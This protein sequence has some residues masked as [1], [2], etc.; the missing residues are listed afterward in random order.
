MVRSRRDE[1]LDL[2]LPVT[3]SGAPEVVRRL[4]LVP[5][6]WCRADCVRQPDHYLDPDPSVSVQ[7]LQQHLASDAHRPLVARGT[8]KPNGSRHCRLTLPARRRDV[9]APA[10]HRIPLRSLH[11]RGDAALSLAV[12]VR[13][14]RDATWHQ[15]GPRRLF[16]FVEHGFDLPGGRLVLRCPCDHGGRVPALEVE[17]AGPGGH[18]VRIPAHTSTPSRLPPWR[19]ARR[20]VQSTTRPATPFRWGGISTNTTGLLADA[21]HGEHRPLEGDEVGGDND[22]S[23]GGGLVGLRPARGLVQVVADVHEMPSAVALDGPR[24]ATLLA[25]SLRIPDILDGN[26]NPS[27]T[28][29]SSP[30]TRWQTKFHGDPVS[31]LSAKPQPSCLRYA[32]LHPRLK[33]KVVLLDYPCPTKRK[34]DSCR[35][36]AEQEPTTPPD[37]LDISSCSPSDDHPTIARINLR[38]TVGC[39]RCQLHIPHTY[40]RFP[41][42]FERG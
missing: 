31:Y 20:R 6:L 25:L 36:R 37:A 14:P 3:A 26:G 11:V 24:L 16:E 10:P 2:N 34:T 33:H 27:T 29:F 4:L 32:Q 17:R 15:P 19:P 22:D 8:A 42:E 38:P 13:D 9:Q 18:R 30:D 23:L 12:H 40:H 5:D 39:T 7:Q 41:A 21:G 35:S 1:V 28:E